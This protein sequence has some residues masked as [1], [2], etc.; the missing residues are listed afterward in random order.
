M[1]RRQILDHER[2]MRNA[3]ERKERQRAYYRAHKEQCKRAVSKC[4]LRGKGL[5]TEEELETILNR[6]KWL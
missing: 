4:K 1:T 6:C 5:Y 3:E 2:Y